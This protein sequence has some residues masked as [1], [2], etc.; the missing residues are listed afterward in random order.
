ML[1]MGSPRD[2]ASWITTLDPKP[3]GSSCKTVS[4]EGSTEVRPC[5]AILCNWRVWVPPPLTWSW[6]VEPDLNWSGLRPW[7]AILSPE[8]IWIIWILSHQS[9]WVAVIFRIG[10]IWIAVPWL[11][12]AHIWLQQIVMWCKFCVISCVCYWN[13]TLS[14]LGGRS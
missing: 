11:T 3:S 2:L 14:K 1:E 12:L 10:P 5:E 7:I 8:N 13:A 4:F 6:M 9:L